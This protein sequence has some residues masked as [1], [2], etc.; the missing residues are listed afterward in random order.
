MDN[1]VMFAR[2]CETRHRGLD[3]LLNIM[4]QPF[5]RLLL[6][7]AVATPECA[8]VA[9]AVMQMRVVT[10]RILLTS[11]SSF[12]V[13]HAE[14]SRIVRQ[15]NRLYSVGHIASG[16]CQRQYLLRLA[17]PRAGSPTGITYMFEC[18]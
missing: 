9:R 11:Y 18:L 3:G 14:S 2:V 17:L 5:C 1:G 13:D 10:A 12:R 6:G 4:M 7:D 16:I 15:A 8:A